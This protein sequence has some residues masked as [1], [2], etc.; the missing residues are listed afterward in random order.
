V[1]VIALILLSL[2]LDSGFINISAE[3]SLPESSD[4]GDDPDND[5]ADGLDLPGV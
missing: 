3:F 1:S 5:Y 2:D 4:M